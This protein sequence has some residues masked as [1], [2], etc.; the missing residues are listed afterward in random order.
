MTA[1]ATSTIE[2]V[3]VLRRYLIGVSAAA[4]LT[5]AAA[6]AQTYGDDSQQT[7]PADTE[8]SQPA[9]ADAQESQ[10][11][12]T[13]PS[14]Q[15]AASTTLTG[16]VYREEDVPGRSPNIAE[17]AGV[18]EDYILAVNAGGAEPGSA[19]TSGGAVGTSGGT[20]A[21]SMYKLE[22]ASDE[23]LKSMV[24]KRVE[25]TGRV[26]AEAGDTAGA[27]PSGDESPGPDRIELP[28]FE[29]SSIREVGGDCP[30]RPDA[31]R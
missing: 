15:A 19:G 6:G 2:E 5:T 21:G 7:Q 29:V 8:Q 17:Q 30:D 23:Q 14:S 1:E 18:L 26:D 20:A 28:E 31:A 11:A 12:T 24:G 10:P 4:L 22:H 9:P 27:A 3:N 13:A 16:C 25:V